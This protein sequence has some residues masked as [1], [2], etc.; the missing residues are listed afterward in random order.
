MKKQ[1][2][3]LLLSGSLTACISAG[4]TQTNNSENEV[5]APV[6]SIVSDHSDQSSEEEQSFP[7]TEIDT[8]ISDIDESTSSAITDTSAVE[9]EEKL[10]STKVGEEGSEFDY[11]LYTNHVEI[12]K[13]NGTNVSITI[14][15]TIEDKPVTVIKAS[16]FFNR[17]FKSN[18]VSVSLPNTLKVLGEYA[19]YSTSIVS[20][21]I[22]DS[23]ERIEYEAFSNCKNLK[24]VKFPSSLTY[25]GEK[26]F[27]GSP[28]AFSEKLVLPEG[29]KTI[30]NYAFYKNNS[31]TELII[32]KGMTTINE[33]TFYECKN[34]KKVELPE[35]ISVIARSAFCKCSSLE[36]INI[37]S[38]I[39]EI[40]DYAFSETAVKSI[41][42][43]D[44]ISLGTFCFSKCTGLKNVVVPK[45]TQFTNS[46]SGQFNS[47][48]SIE[49]AE[50][51][52][53]VVSNSMF[54]YC[55]NL[56][57]IKISEGAVTIE[58]DAFYNC[59]SKAEK[60]EIHIPN[61]VVLIDE[62]FIHW[63]VDKSKFTI[64]GKKGSAAEKIAT[65]N[66]FNF[67]EE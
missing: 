36:D 12:L 50:I 30:D 25:I 5:T 9:V 40:G 27:E 45:G 42:L 55:S 39:K 13:Y 29:L 20:V 35:T 56:K 32:P 53:E 7:D 60:L 41:S 43:S 11:E 58:K 33:G 18:M 6:N 67:V 15:D 34:L 47:C 21:D 24:T 4:C 2:L 31:I 19:F 37:T 54:S 1:L 10:I 48:S 59:G 64:Y 44:N 16:D 17:P 57:E 65:E 62:K 66:G 63:N 38:N 49:T 26:A 52:S 61:S 22:P 28:N 23:V 51:N 8:E 14:P 3:A 46:C